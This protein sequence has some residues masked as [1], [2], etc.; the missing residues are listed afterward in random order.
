MTIAACLKDQ[1][2]ATGRFGKNHLGDLDGMLRIP[3]G[4]F[5]V[6]GDLLSFERRE[7]EPG[8]PDYPNEKDFP[9]SADQFDRAG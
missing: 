9:N 4:G 2:Y 1:G 3:T 6:F 8:S 7:E 5:A